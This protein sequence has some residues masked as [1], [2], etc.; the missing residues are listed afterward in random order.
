VTCSTIIRGPVS[1][2]KESSQSSKLEARTQRDTKE[3]VKVPN[4]GTAVVVAMLFKTVRSRSIRI[5]SRPI[6]RN[7][8]QPLTRNE[9]PMEDETVEVVTMED[10]VVE[11][12]ERVQV[13]NGRDPRVARTTKE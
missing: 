10:A 6:K 9:V 12:E 3:L 4:A 7:T 13:L 8:L 5:E 1:I 2:Q 11:D